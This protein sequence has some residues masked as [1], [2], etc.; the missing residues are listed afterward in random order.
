MDAVSSAW[1]ATWMGAPAPDSGRERTRRRPCDPS[2]A[3]VAHT[4]MLAPLPVSC[5]G[6]VSYQACRP[7]S[8]PGPG[9]HAPLQQS[10]GQ[11]YQ[12]GRAWRGRRTPGAGPAGSRPV[13][14]WRGHPPSPWTAPT[15]S[16]RACK[17]TQHGEGVLSGPGGQCKTVGQPRPSPCY[18]QR[19]CAHHRH[20][21][22]VHPRPHLHS[23]RLAA[24]PRAHGHHA[25]AVAGAK[26]KPLL[27][28]APL[29]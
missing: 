20:H 23:P 9:P 5:A 19:P 26:R 28:A 8:Q 18:Q 27:T 2:P 16:R 25:A 29:P 1:V 13:P 24:V 14:R 10:R 4:R 22:R 15:S 11:R 17:Q 21:W 3:T 7:T 6:E 12:L